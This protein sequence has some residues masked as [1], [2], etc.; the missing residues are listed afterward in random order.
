[1]M[2]SNELIAISRQPEG[3]G[4]MDLLGLAVISGQRSARAMEI[5]SSSLADRRQ[6]LR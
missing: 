2:K 3:D 5:S 4:A 1:M 6:L